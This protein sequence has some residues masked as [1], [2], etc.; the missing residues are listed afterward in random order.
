[1]SEIEQ[2]NVQEITNDNKNNKVDKTDNID[3][4]DLIKINKNTFCKRFKITQLKFENETLQ[5]KLNCSLINQKIQKMN[6]KR[7]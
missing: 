6:I 3:V 5:K 7:K 2:K 4:K 1:M